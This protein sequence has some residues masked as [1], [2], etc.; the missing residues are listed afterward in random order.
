M[1]MRIESETEPRRLLGLKLPL[2]ASR[3]R[4]AEEEKARAIQAR[5]LPG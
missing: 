1:I 4:K 5:L 2:A 3:A